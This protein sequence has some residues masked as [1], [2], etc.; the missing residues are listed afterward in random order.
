MTSLPY[1]SVAHK[2][3][4][5]RKPVSSCFHRYLSVDLAKALQHFKAVT[6]TLYII[7][8]KIKYMQYSLI[9]SFGVR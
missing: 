3:L 6:Q 4:S 9:T 7:S 8:R 5:F 2:K 1:N